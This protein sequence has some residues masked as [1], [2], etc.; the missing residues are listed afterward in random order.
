MAI[1]YKT[2]LTKTTQIL[3]QWTVTS[4]M[5]RA[6][7]HSR[8]MMCLTGQGKLDK[9]LPCLLDPTQIIQ[10][11]FIIILSVFIRYDHSNAVVCRKSAFNFFIGLQ[12][13]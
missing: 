5:T 1:Q 9:R 13:S 8:Q 10:V 12:M 3:L 4:R 2:N 7:G 11:L 6:V